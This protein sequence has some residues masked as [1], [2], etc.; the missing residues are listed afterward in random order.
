M[1][2]GAK[3]GDARVGTEA[4]FDPIFQRLIDTPDSALDSLR[5]DPAAFEAEL[6]AE[7]GGRLSADAAIPAFDAL[8]VMIFDA[9]GRAVAV[10]G[11]NWLPAYP[12]F[13]ALVGAARELRPGS[14]LLV[15]GRGDAPALHAIW[16]DMA[17]TAQWNLPRQV[18]DLTEAHPSGKLVLIAGGAL[19][20][21]A[22]AAACRAFGLTTHESRVASAVVRTGSGRRA[23]AETGLAYATV[24]E[25]LSRTSQRLRAPNLPALVQ[26]LIAA[27]FGVLPGEGDPATT[28]AD[29]LPLSLRQAKLSALIADGASRDEA[30][31]ALR[32]STAVVKKELETIYATLGVASAAELARLVV[33]VGALRLLA[34]S[35]DG[36]PGYS[37]PAVEPTRLTLRGRGGEVIAWSDYGPGSGRPVLVVHSNWQCRTVPRALLAELHRHGFRPIAIDRPGFGSTAFGGSTAVDP[38]GQAIEDVERILDLLRI[39]R[40]PILARCGAQFVTAFKQRAPDRVGPV[41][42]VSPS[43]QTSEGGLRRGIVGV[44]KEAFY[45][46]PRMIEFF[47]RIIGAQVSLRRTETLTRAIVAGSP[48]DEAL[49]DDPQF[50]C[51]RLRAIRPF[52]TGALSGA[53][54]EERIISNGG[55]DFGI[56]DARDWIVM[57]GGEDTHNSFEEVEGYWSRIAP[58]ARFVRVPDGGRFM[59][60]SHASLVVQTFEGLLAEDAR[61]PIPAIAP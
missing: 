13:P 45:R 29:M 57:Q 54:N 39:D 38:Y 34:R 8:G 22:I 16:A 61:A 59:T 31:R 26:M 6:L 47:F 37:D 44:V 12:D 2:H 56:V 7:E 43:P 19:G 17:E 25:A 21:G 58:A 20:E 49:L 42:L 40:I 24:R 11:G 10:D 50:L 28:L 27:A 36:A 18:R 5:R 48:A 33:E 51:D 1:W 32:V 3:K 60:A 23:A 4:R 14:R 30:A 41:L 15:I 9:S 55:Y 52:S 46:S 53:V 35:T